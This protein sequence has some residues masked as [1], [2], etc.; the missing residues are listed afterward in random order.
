[1][2]AYMD[3]PPY[4]MFRIRKPNAPRKGLVADEHKDRQGQWCKAEFGKEN[5]AVTGCGF[6]STV[7]MSD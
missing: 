2:H 6:R 3:T 7:G 1:M 4:G 5:S